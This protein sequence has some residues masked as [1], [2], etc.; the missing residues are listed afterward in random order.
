MDS[1]IIH[2]ARQL[3]NYH[4]LNLPLEK[5]DCIVGLGSYDLR[6]AE[7]CGELY[8][9]DWAPLI[10][11]SGHLGNWTRTLWD[12]SEAEVFAEHAIARGVPAHCIKLETE[13]TNIGENLK[14][15]R[16]FL[17]A[18]DIHVRSV[19]I[20]TKPSTERRA[21]ATSK[22]VW[23]EIK[24]L[25]TSPPM[26][27]EQ[28]MSGGIQENL[29]HEMV[30]D[31]Q[32]IRAYPALGFQIPQDIPADVWEAYERLISLGFDKHLIPSS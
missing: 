27:L 8:E 11:F 22:K 12:K 9:D 20:V 31:I 4:H 26:D 30:G 18:Q 16:E 15:T 23:P 24:T 17:V 5:A 3:W 7:R 1:N 21:F 13:S 19:L 32:R 28:Q 14:F 6:V 10:V 29:I 25:I 2:L